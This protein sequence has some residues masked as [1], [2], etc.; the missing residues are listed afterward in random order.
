MAPEGL[1]QRSAIITAVVNAGDLDPR[2]QLVGAARSRDG[3]YGVLPVP[4]QAFY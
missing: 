4:D 2:G 1:Y 3:C